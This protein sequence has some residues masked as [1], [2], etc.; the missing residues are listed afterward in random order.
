MATGKRDFYEVLGVGK[1]ASDEDLKKAYRKLAMKYHPDRNLDNP[2][3]EAKFKEAKE[4]YETLADPQKRNAYDQFG[5]AGVD[6]SMGGFGGAAGGFAD[7]FGDIFGDI[8]GQGRSAGPQVYK[9]ADL[10]YNMEITLEQAAEGYTTQI[11]VPSWSNCKTC[12]GSGAEPGS[13][14]EECP[15]CDGRGQVRIAQGFFSM[16]QTCPKCRGTGQYIPKPCKTCQGSGKLKEQKTLEI[17]IPAGIDDGMR[18]RSVGN[19]EPGINGGPSGDLYV[20]V[21]VKEHPVFERD[22]SDLHIQMPISFATATL[23]GDI[24]VPTLGGRVELTIPEGTQTGKTFRLRSKGIKQLRSALMGDLYVH[25]LLETPVKLSE[26]QKSLLSQFD[27]SL[28]S[29][30][31][32]QIDIIRFLVERS[33][34]VCAHLGLL[35]QSVHLLGGY[36]VQGKSKDAATQ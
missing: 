30:G 5:H 14:I 17:K 35:P 7:A 32:W 1:N 9:G 28:R 21:H 13:K 18:V 4:A 33:V 34:P 24:E 36:K 11:R 3:A 12:S 6:P 26:E 27:E 10:R 31:S 8:F 19:G 23:G 22:G 2:S 29:G 20:E 25:V 16:Q 15:T